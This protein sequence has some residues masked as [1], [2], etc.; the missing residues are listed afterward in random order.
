M[1]MCEI[2]LKTYSKDQ[3]FLKTFIS[4]SDPKACTTLLDMNCPLWLDRTARL[5]AASCSFLECCIPAKD[6]AT[7]LSKDQDWILQRFAEE[8]MNLKTP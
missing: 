7:Y 1:S 6:I 8:G 3:C 5:A 4:K 2:G